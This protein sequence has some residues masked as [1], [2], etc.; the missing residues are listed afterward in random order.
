MKP[1][2]REAAKAGAPVQTRDGYS[3]RILCFNRKSNSLPI[4]ALY[5]HSEDKRETIG[6]YT[7]NG[8][9]Y[10][11][12]SQSCYDLVMAPVKKEGWINI[13]KKPTTEEKY[14]YTETVWPTE[15][16]AIKR[17]SAH[18]IATAKVEWEE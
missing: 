3:V 9:V 12:E 16:D 1:F 13:Y 18:H 15:E 14:V 7:E 10:V 6:A 5:Y 17:K 2:N 4:V 11:D 8:Y